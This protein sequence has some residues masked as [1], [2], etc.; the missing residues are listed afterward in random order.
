M[1]CRWEREEERRGKERGQVGLHY[2]Q[3]DIISQSSE[4]YPNSGFHT[5]L[6]NKLY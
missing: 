5:V 2:S 4:S 3:M 6:F 1:A